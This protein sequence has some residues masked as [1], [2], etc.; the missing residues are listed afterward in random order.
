[1]G[2]YGDI[3]ARFANALNE[4]K[5]NDF[6]KAKGK[7]LVK[8]RESGNIYAV[9]K[10][11]LSNHVPPSKEEIETYKQEQDN[12]KLLSAG[13]QKTAKAYNNLKDQVAWDN[14]EDQKSLENSV[15]KIFSGKKLS[16]EE[17]ET[18]KKYFKVADK[19]RELAIYM[20]TR[21]AG[22]FKQNA[23]IKLELGSGDGAIKLK[24]MLMDAGVEETE[25]V[26]TDAEKLKINNKDIDPNKINKN[27]IKLERKIEKNDKGEVESVKFGSHS[28]KRLD[29]PVDL[30]KA[31]ET[32]HPNKSKKE[33]DVMA[34]R[35]STAIER[36][37]TILEQFSEMKGEIEVLETVE[38]A[39]VNTAEGR[40][41]VLDAYPDKLAKSISDLI[42]DKPNKAE[43]SFL[44]DFKKLKSI[45][46]EEEYENAVIALTKKM[47]SMDDIKKGAPSL[48]E[49]M[50]YLNM[51]KK[52]YPVYLPASANMAV[53]DIVSFPDLSDLDPEDPNYSKK[54]A[55]NIQYTVN[56]Q[57]QGGMSVKKDGGAASAARE[58]L[59]QTLFKN[60]KTK[61]KLVQLIDN[62]QNVMGSVTRKPNHEEAEKQLAEI[63][64]WAKD[65]GLWDGKP[66]PAGA[67]GKTPADWAQNQIDLWT[68][69]GKFKGSKEHIETVRKSLELHARQALL[70]AQVYNKD[71]RGQLFGNANM[72]TKK[73]SI[74]I[75]DGINSASL[76]KPLLNS[77]YGFREDKEGNVWPAPNNV[78]GGNL[79]HGEYDAETEEYILKSH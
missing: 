79:V 49:S 34:D 14:E 57:A 73:G 61:D 5:S 29:I 36:N 62:Y 76:M 15:N 70:L 65:G 46:D 59:D 77:G 12:E 74:D 2:T 51:I 69:K 16:S 18:V 64:K 75:T 7:F 72:D 6:K 28:I 4:A 26:T 22:N 58:K 78:Y 38:D 24:K 31:L 71:C 66:I 30:Y 3:R 63:E 68:E 39:D 10:V 44:D 25:S 45:E 35:I 21:S 23:R 9:D 60:G 17:T 56:L 40:K 32:A 27:S 50:V 43:Q 52:G 20:P 13:L 53:S 67:G 55:S 19:N 54:L 42:G 11:D 41:K 47:E 33:L 1:M 37:N 48:A 8:N